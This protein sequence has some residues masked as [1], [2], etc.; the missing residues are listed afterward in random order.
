MKPGISFQRILIAKT[1][2]LGDLVI[3]LPMAAAIKRHYP[4]ATVIFLTCP[5][6]ATV[7]RR[8]LDVDEVYSLPEAAADLPPLLKSLNIDV[9][10]QANT[11]KKRGLAAK[12]AAIP[13][14]IGS[15]Y[16]YYNWFLCTHTVAISRCFR[17]LNKRLLDLQYL[18]P[19]HIIAD[20]L[21]AVP[22]Y[23]RFA[24]KTD[25]ALTGRFGLNVNKHR[26]ILHPASITS[27]AH[28]WPLASYA[29]L[30][31]SLDP[32]R[33]QWL[34]TGTAA[35]RAYL[36][37]LLN[38][39]GRQADVVDTV[40]QLTLDELMTLMMA[41][42][43]LVAGS[44]GPLHLAAALGLHTLGLFQSK[45]S[46]YQR[47]APVGRAAAILHSTTPCCGDKNQQACPCIVAISPASVKERVLAWFAD[48]SSTPPCSD[49]LSQP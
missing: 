19:L 5:N 36:T 34:I 33:Y 4:E 29:Q 45:P 48:D 25:H 15:L 49:S 12:A 41:C 23:Y 20:D 28:R 32:E 17:H 10:I 26:I 7:A 30:I 2:H 6:T 31:D 42:D 18:R 46:I 40:G 21:N 47:W 14:R 27:Q 9:F 35:E 13:I 11:S 37:P 24:P 43:G 16:R 22:D 1:S 8:C 38:S 44:T 39:P 3:S